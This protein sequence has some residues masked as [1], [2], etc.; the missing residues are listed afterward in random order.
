MNNSVEKLLILLIPS[1]SQLTDAV[2]STTHDEMDLSKAFHSVASDG[3]AAV[4]S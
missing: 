4:V 3:K 1:Q 2:L